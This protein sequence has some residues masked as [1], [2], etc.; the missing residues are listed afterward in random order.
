MLFSNGNYSHFLFHLSE[1]FRRLGEG[2]GG[3][4]RLVF[5]SSKTC[6]RKG[7]CPF[8]ALLEL[9]LRFG[10]VKVQKWPKIRF[11]T[12]KA[13]FCG[14]KAP[15]LGIS[16]IKARNGQNPVLMHALDETNTNPLPPSPRRRKCLLRSSKKWLETTIE[17]NICE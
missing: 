1:H 14:L 7:F 5:V 10:A 17:N 4:V 3:D 12:G 9:I 11:F 2:G 8:R 6:I 13:V 16:S 15:N